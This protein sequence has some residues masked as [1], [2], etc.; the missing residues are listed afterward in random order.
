MEYYQKRIKKLLT[1]I[2]REKNYKEK[3]VAGYYSLLTSLYYENGLSVLTVSSVRLN[4]QVNK[5]AIE[6][7]KD[8]AIL[9]GYTSPDGCN[10]LKDIYG[11]VEHWLYQFTN[12]YRRN[13]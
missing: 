2:Q 3:I 13:R 12:E 4:A 11:F 10:S 1:V 6:I 5:F 7:I 8:K 9:V